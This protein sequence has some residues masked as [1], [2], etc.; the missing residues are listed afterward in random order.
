[1]EIWVGIKLPSHQILQLLRTRCKYKRQAVDDGVHRA[2]WGYIRGVV[3]V[4]YALRPLCLPNDKSKIEGKF[5]VV[6]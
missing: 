4:V 1:V 2:I 3:D 5:F 6:G